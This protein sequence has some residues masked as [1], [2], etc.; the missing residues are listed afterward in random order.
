[1][2]NLQL[3]ALLP[4]QVIVRGENHQVAYHVHEVG[5]NN[6]NWSG[7]TPVAKL[8]VGSVS[9]TGTSA[10]VNQAGGT[11]TATFTAAQT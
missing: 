2:P 8:V 4:T 3:A 11:A 7:Y 6:F 5:G 10:V 1:M 9:V